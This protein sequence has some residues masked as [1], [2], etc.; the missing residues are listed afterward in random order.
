MNNDY[1]FS[2]SYLAIGT[3]VVAYDDVEYILHNLQGTY[4]FENL[5]AEMKI[6]FPSDT[7]NENRK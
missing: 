5:N 1:L 7:L 3:S 6:F 4:E 2:C